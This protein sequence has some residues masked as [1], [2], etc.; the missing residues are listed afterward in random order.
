MINYPGKLYIKANFRSEDV[1]SGEII[2]GETN[3]QISIKEV[4]GNILPVMVL[5]VDIPNIAIDF[6]SNEGVEFQLT[7][8][9]SEDS[10]VTSSWHMYKFNLI[11]SHLNA[12]LTPRRTFVNDKSIE[13]IN[14]SSINAIE[15]I[16]SRYFKV[17]KESTRIFDDRMKWINPNDTI[18]NYID[19]IWLHSYGE[20]ALLLPAILADGTYRIRE[21][22]KPDPQKIYTMSENIDNS[23][24]GTLETNKFHVN[25][26]DYW[27]IFGVQQ[28]NYIDLSGNSNSDVVDI[29]PTFGSI[30]N[31]NSFKTVTHRPSYM[32]ENISDNYF[33]AKATNLT[34]LGSFAAGYA[35]TVDFEDLFGLRV[36]DHVDLVANVPGLVQSSEL[37]SGVS[38]VTEK[39]TSI[40]PKALH[41]KCTVRRDGFTV[42]NV[43]GVFI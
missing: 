38:L 32:S 5:D 4:A 25:T 34:R 41:T 15:K 36:L 28:Q 18:R 39:L 30:F 14:D 19:Q 20:Q 8:G 16:A 35:T 40:T 21:V 13:V 24:F 22:L 9:H 10:S 27:N 43:Q 3:F 6:Y 17:E 1:S 2:D 42:N 31:R 29:N 37:Q 12:I 7:Y 33:K 26:S 11:G 23:D